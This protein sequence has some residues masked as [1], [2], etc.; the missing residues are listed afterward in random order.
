MNT[1]TQI[2]S[3]PKLNVFL[4]LGLLAGLLVA[5]PFSHTIAASNST[6]KAEMVSAYGKL[7]L[8][9]EL[10]QG[11]TDK[12]VH[13]LSRGAGYNLFLTEKEAVLAL[14]PKPKAKEFRCF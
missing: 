4:A 9:F 2:F 13:Y 1:P 10:N 6:A 5:L 11:E 12:R 8:S 3:K 7:P 14:Q